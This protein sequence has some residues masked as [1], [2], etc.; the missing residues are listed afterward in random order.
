MDQE[1]DNK[2]VSTFPLLYAD[3]H[4]DM[5]ETC[6]CWGF[7]FSSG[8]YSLV[9]DLSA[10]LEILIQRYI[11]DNPEIECLCGCKKSKHTRTLGECRTS[12]R[13]PIV[14]TSGFY[15]RSYSRNK[16]IYYLQRGLYYIEWRYIRLKGKIFNWLADHTPIYNTLYCDCKCYQPNHPRAAQMK[17]KFG[18]L[19]LYMT[20]GTNEMYDL[21]HEATEL[22][23][24]TCEICGAEGKRLSRN[25]WLKT[26]CPKCAMEN[27]YAKLQEDD[28]R[29]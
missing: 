1:L 22:S 29:D 16:V 10:R 25:Y 4:G 23:L 27:K 28:D 17:E 15:T 13:L 9:W 12:F 19:C 8:W 6:A 5:R 3:R 21:I 14:K 18:E 26:L 11:A 24:K 2:L 7:E 20:S